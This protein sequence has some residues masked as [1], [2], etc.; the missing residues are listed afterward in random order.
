[1]TIVNKKA[2]ESFTTPNINMKKCIED[3]QFL[4]RLKEGMSNYGNGDRYDWKTIAKQTLDFF[5]IN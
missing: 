3:K 2:L 5:N 1:M 4:A